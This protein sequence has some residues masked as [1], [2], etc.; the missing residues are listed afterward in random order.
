MQIAM[1][2]KP[3]SIVIGPPMMKSDVHFRF[4]GLALTILL[5]IFFA[6]LWWP[7]PVSLVS[8]ARQLP[9]SA[10]P[11]P[12]AAAAPPCSSSPPAAERE[13]VGD[14]PSAYRNYGKDVLASW[15]NADASAHVCLGSSPP[16]INGGADK[17]G[18]QKFMTA[19]SR[20]C[21]FRNLC[22]S[23]SRFEYFRGADPLPFEHSNSAGDVYDPP[24]PLLDLSNDDAFRK[25]DFLRVTAVD[26]AIPSHYTR[27]DPDT[28]HVIAVG[29]FFRQ[30]EKHGNIGHEFGDSTWVVFNTMLDTG[31]LSTD[32]QVVYFDMDGRHAV[33]EGARTADMLS[34]RPLA[35]M[36]SFPGPTC[37]SWA[38]AGSGARYLFSPSLPTAAAW[39]AMHDFVYA[40]FGLD[41]GPRRLAESQAD[42]AAASP[43][44]RIL[45]RYKDHRHTFSNY[46]QIIADLQRCF[47]SSSVE[48]YDPGNVTNTFHAEF[49]ELSRTDVYITPGG[50]GSFMAPFLP[51]NS[52]VIFGAACW[53]SVAGAT[54]GV[55]SNPTPGGACC[56]QVERFLWSAL[57][58]LHVSYYN[59]MGA[60]TE[61]RRQPGVPANG[62]LD[63]DYPVDTARLTKLVKRA[64]QLSKGRT[65]SDC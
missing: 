40:R 33:L 22:W 1:Q 12:T 35:S 21:V 46:P 25:G 34:S 3:Q 43:P 6:G 28:V 45:V 37:F 63:F 26:G 9:P 49:L 27:T 56:V 10:P 60:V 41:G 7:Q 29:R 32:N 42:A 61:L 62:V 53:P 20:K 16:D 19:A 14:S 44:I 58:Y 54:E 23:G 38:A 57:P 15:S 11:R 59:Y 39:R 51:V 30:G 52:A 5:A 55:C 13:R 47:P 17:F 24:D 8:L 48:L 18:P 64:L 36:Q 50:G 65:F 2:R 31:M 4:I